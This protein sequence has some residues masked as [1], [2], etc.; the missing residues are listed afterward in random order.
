MPK[1]EQILGK[2]INKLVWVAPGWT[3]RLMLDLFC[4]PQKGRKFTTKEQGFI[5]KA[6]WENLQLDGQKIQ[7]YTWGTGSKKVLLAHGFNSNAARWRILAK[8]L[9]DA[10][11]QIIAFDIPAHGNSGWNRINGL[12]YARVVE[13]VMAH[14]Q[15]EAVVGH[16][17]AGIAFAYYFTKMEA[18]P[19]EKIVLMGVPNEL[20]DIT[21]VF[22]QMLSVNDRVQHAYLDAFKTQFGYPVDY[23]TLSNFYKEIQVPGLIIHDEADDIASFE[24]AKRIADSWPAARFFPTKNLGHSLQGKLVYNEIKDFLL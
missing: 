2:A 10:D 23:F 14:F 8:V 15:P 6:N 5:D 11:Y 16:S 9:E 17:F 7:C 22:F 4:R 19:V 12:L 18:L 1:L 20:M 13:V 24:G 21:N 3:G